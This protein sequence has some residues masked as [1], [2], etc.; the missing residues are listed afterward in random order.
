MKPTKIKELTP[1]QRKLLDK[2]IDSAEIVMF[3]KR[4]IVKRIKKANELKTKALIMME[5]ADDLLTEIRNELLY[6]EDKTN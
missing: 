1:K 5:E 2:F 3:D 4:D 6:G